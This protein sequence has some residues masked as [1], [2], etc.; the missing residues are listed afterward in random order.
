MKFTYELE[1][2]NYLSILDVFVVS[3]QGS[4]NGAVYMK[5]T[6]RTNSVLS[7]HSGHITRK[8]EWKLKFFEQVTFSN[9]ED[10]RNDINY[11]VGDFSKSDYYSHIIKM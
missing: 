11:I 10:L 1:I 6:Q 3:S 5:P 4:V 9:H 2:N 7:N 8:D